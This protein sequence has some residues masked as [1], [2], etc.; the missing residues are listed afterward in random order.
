[1][2]TESFWATSAIAA[3]HFDFGTPL[4][5]DERIGPQCGHRIL[6]TF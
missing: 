5:Q 6:A 3:T 1:M 4:K 2:K